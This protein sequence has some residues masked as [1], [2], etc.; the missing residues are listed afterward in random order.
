MMPFLSCFTRNRC[1]SV[2]QVDENTLTATCRLQDT[3]TDAVVEIDVA[4]PDLEITAARGAFQRSP[5]QECVQIDADLKKVHGVRIGSGLL[6]ILKGLI[7]EASE[8]A[9]LAYIV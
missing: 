8:C 2:E 3:L 6:K 9:E 4:L 1:S 7:C 5:R